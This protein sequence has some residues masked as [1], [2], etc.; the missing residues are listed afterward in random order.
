[1]ILTL[2]PSSSERGDYDRKMLLPRGG[3]EG[4]CGELEGVFVRVGVEGAIQ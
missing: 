2:E 4:R 3:E 1:M